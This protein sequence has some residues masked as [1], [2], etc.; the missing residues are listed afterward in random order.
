MSEALG[1]Q[2]RQPAESRKEKAH[3]RFTSWR[4]LAYGPWLVLLALVAKL[5]NAAALDAASG[6][7]CGFESRRGHTNFSKSW[8]RE[9]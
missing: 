6:Q 9:S 2:Q 1:H 5:V 3:K 4:K 8:S 7:D